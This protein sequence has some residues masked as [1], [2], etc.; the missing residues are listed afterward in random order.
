M[1]KT[2]SR[3]LAL[4]LMASLILSGCGSTGTG[5][6]TQANNEKPASGESSAEKPEGESIVQGEPITDLVISKIATSELS[7][8][9]LLNSETSADSQ[10]LTNLWD[11]LLEVNSY[12][13]LVPAIAEEWGTEDGGLTGP[14]ICVTMQHG[15]MSTAMKKQNVFRRTF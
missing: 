4:A 13:E 14:S 15:W 7:T 9:N 11:G 5:E 3:I 2:A 1:K 10:Y 8:F 6:N 12:G